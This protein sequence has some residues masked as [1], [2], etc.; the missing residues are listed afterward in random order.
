MQMTIGLNCNLNGQLSEATLTVSGEAQVNADIT[1]AG[2]ATN[3]HV[4][5]SFKITDLT[6]GGL[7]LI[8]G[9]Q[10]LTVKTNDSG[11]PDDTFEVPAGG[12]VQVTAL[13]ADITDLYVTNGS[14]DTETT[15][16]LRGVKDITP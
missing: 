9:G 11:T 4:V 10:A 6:A 3:L 12:F 14:A 5:E 15:L 16:K 7:L 13:A 1:V 8:S 2:G